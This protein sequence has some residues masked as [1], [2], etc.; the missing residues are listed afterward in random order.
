M[1]AKN[2]VDQVSKR[3]EDT[4]QIVENQLQANAEKVASL[5]KLLQKLKGQSSTP[6]NYNISSPLQS[7]HESLE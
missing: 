4:Q 6:Q 5:E 1:Q 2:A 3:L 7:A